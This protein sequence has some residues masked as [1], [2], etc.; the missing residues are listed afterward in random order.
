MRR[1]NNP[2]SIFFTATVWVAVIAVIAYGAVN[3]IVK[4][5]TK[6]EEMFHRNTV[7]NVTEK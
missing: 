1:N 4:F 5:N 2:L 3:N 7:D 6:V